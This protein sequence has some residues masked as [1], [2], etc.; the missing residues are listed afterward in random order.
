MIR[1]TQSVL[2]AHALKYLVPV[3]GLRARLSRRRETRQLPTTCLDTSKVIMQHAMMSYS[4]QYVSSP[5]FLASASANVQH[6]TRAGCWRWLR[7]YISPLS[8]EST[9]QVRNRTKTGEDAR[10][11]EWT[12]ES[13]QNNVVWHQERSCTLLPQA[14]THRAQPE[15]R[16]RGCRGSLGR[17]SYSWG[18][19]VVHGCFPPG[20]ACKIEK[21]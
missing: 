8:V 20:T 21:K 10:D 16:T 9:R 19:R 5:T 13:R 4:S 11:L 3:W 14:Q 6:I 15:N 2:K 7:W 12:F 18:C 1:P 17:C